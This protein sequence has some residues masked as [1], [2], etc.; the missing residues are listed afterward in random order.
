MHEAA[1]VAVA[2]QLRAAGKAPLYRVV[3]SVPKGSLNDARKEGLVADVTEA[4]MRLEPCEQWRADPNRVW[5]LVND[6]PDGDW[7]A[8]GRIVRLRDLAEMFDV[9]RRSP[10]RYAEIEFDKR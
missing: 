8:G 2:G 1:G 9:A 6:V 5:C 7:G 3:V 4:I 10:E